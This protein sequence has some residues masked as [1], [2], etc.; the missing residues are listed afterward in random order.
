M[1]ASRA[2]NIAKP[3]VEWVAMRFGT[4]EVRHVPLGQKVLPEA[5]FLLRGYRSPL[6]RK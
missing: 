4:I 1:G 6:S 3:V 5:L 2:I